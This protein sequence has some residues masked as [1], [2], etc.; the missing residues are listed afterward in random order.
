MYFAPQPANGCVVDTEWGHGAND[1][2]NGA[3]R[4]HGCWMMGADLGCKVFVAMRSEVVRDCSLK[5]L[6]AGTA[7]IEAP[8]ALSP[9]EDW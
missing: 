7:Q 2:L 5:Q 8:G 4:T 1:E 9:I 3:S 6:P